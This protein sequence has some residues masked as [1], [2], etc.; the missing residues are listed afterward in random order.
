MEQAGGENE[1]SKKPG[2]S[3]PLLSITT[4]TLSHWQEAS[5]GYKGCFSS[6]CS[7]NHATGLGSLSQSPMMIP[8]SAAITEVARLS[9]SLTNA[10]C[11]LVAAAGNLGSTN[12]L[13]ETRVK[14]T[15]S[16]LHLPEDLLYILELF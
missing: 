2:K 6:A 5:M 14:Y 16:W 7:K 4:T 13:G 1:S 3:G 9:L 15:D 11:L 8:G 10:H 12:Q